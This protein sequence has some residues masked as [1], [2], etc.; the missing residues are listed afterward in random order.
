M[1]NKDKLF[2]TF[3]EILYVVAKS[4]GII[5]NEEITALK[6]LVASHPFGKE[7]QWSFDYEQSKNTPIDMLYKKAVAIL[8]DHGPDQEYEFLIYALEKIAHASEG[9]HKNEEE[10][11]TNF[12]RDLLERLKNFNYDDIEE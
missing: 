10:V 3:G 12:S 9:L 1:A 11:I 7:I 6:D 4:D 8:S 5:Q 2:Q